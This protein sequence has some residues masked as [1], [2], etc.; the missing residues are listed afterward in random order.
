MPLI[1]HSYPVIHNILWITLRQQ[2][3]TPT[4][5][6]CRA[7]S[8]LSRGVRNDTVSAC[9]VVREEHDHVVRVHCPCFFGGPT[10][11][12]EKASAL[13]QLLH[14][15]GG[16]FWISVSRLPDP[17]NRPNKPWLRLFPVDVETSSSWQLETVYPT[18]LTSYPCHPRYGRRLAPARPR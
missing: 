7:G 10:S 2:F 3:T 13:H 9:R 14:P 8:L 1:H 4:F 15:L 17:R 16:F 6:L 12:A 5:G 18:V 11:L